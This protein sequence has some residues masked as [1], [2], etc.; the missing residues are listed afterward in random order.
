MLRNRIL[1]SPLFFGIIAAVAYGQGVII[2][3]EPVPHP[4]WPDRVTTTPLE[5]K[6]QRVYADTVDGVA[7][8][9]VQQT[10]VNPLRRPV[11]GTYVF[12]LPDGVAV[13]DFSMT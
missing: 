2:I 10:F 13:G 9:S 3:P 6:Y 7:V 12:P 1:L 4:R 5:V 8:T 11:E